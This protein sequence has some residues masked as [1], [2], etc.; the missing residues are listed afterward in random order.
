M[1]EDKSSSR[2]KPKRMS[3]KE[4]QQFISKWTQGLIEEV[5]QAGYYVKKDKNGVDNVR[6]IKQPPVKSIPNVEVKPNDNEYISVE[7]APDPTAET[8]IKN[9]EK[10]EKNKDNIL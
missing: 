8:V 1:S 7:P 3:A 9:K 5:K 4:R 6:K 10:A 2:N